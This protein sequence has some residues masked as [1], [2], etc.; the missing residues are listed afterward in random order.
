MKIVEQNMYDKKITKKI[1]KQKC[2]NYPTKTSL[3]PHFLYTLNIIILNVIAH[4]CIHSIESEFT[5]KPC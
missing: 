5:W 4:P 2:K 3:L 1:T